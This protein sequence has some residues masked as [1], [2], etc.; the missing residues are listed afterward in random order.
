MRRLL[1]LV[2]VVLPV[3]VGAW[4]G[5]QG[6]GVGQGV[7][8]MLSVG[9]YV[10]HHDPCVRAGSVEL[11]HAPRLHAPLSTQRKHT[12]HSTTTPLTLSVPRWPPFLHPSVPSLSQLI[13]FPHP[14]Q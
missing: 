2:L 11:M 1:L 5:F 8:M 7:V 3:Y 12:P 10:F 6:N 14:L 4:V 9:A 13:P